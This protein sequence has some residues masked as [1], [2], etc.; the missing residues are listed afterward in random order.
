MAYPGRVG[1]QPDQGRVYGALA[2][3]ATAISTAA[4]LIRLAAAP[5]LTVAT[6]RM[7]IASLAVV[8]LGVVVDWRR[9]VGLNRRQWG[10]ALASSACLALHFYFW[11]ASLGHT[12]VAS[13]VI[14][15]NANRSWW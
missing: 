1:E 3:G 12:S 10:L 15:V 8:P 6:Y 13:S 4:V 5:A 2:L 11:I 9:L 7:T 14:I